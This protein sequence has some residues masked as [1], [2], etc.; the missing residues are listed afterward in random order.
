LRGSAT[1]CERMMVYIFYKSRRSIPATYSYRNFT[2][3][4]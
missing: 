1:E 4:P 3:C 2:L